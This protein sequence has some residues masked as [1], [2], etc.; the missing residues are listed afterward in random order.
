MSSPGGLQ[1]DF[2]EMLMDSQWWSAEDLRDYQR[3]QLAQLLRHAKA[4]VPF[5]ATRLDAVLKPNGDI[6]WDRW[7]E[8]PIVKRKDMVDHRDA[9]QARELPAGHGPVGVVSTSGSTGMP[10]Q[11]TTSAIGTIANNGLR[12][13]VHRWHDLD[14]SKTL[15][16]RL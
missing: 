10:V 3:S 15:C 5:Y 1:R 13:R 4:N 8:I 16:N 7:T 11:I 12:L 2:Y 6:D 14:W 9:M